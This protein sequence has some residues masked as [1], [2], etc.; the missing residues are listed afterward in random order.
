MG[1]TCWGWRHESSRR[2][3]AAFGPSRPVRGRPVVVAPDAHQLRDG[4]TVAAVAP[5]TRIVYFAGRVVGLLVQ[6]FIDGVLDGAFGM[7][8]EQ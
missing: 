1:A 8:D 7:P 3:R 6:P 2:I 4:A 5:M